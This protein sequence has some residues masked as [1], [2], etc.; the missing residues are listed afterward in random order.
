VGRTPQQ[1]L[2]RSLVGAVCCALGIA[3]LASAAAAPRKVDPRTVPVAS[4]TIGWTR[5][6]AVDFAA[7]RLLAAGGSGA[8]ASLRISPLA[9]LDP[10][11]S[12]PL[13]IT[14]GDV[15]EVI[16]DGS[17]AYVCSEGR[18]T[19]VDL[20]SNSVLRR[21]RTVGA[22]DCALDSSRG[23]LYALSRSFVTSVA[24]QVPQW[25]AEY[26]V[27]AMSAT[28]GTSIARWTVWRGQDAP[29]QVDPDTGDRLQLSSDGRWLYAGLYGIGQVVK[30]DTTSGT[31]VA[32]STVSTPVE[33]IALD[34]QN[35]R[36]LWLGGG[37][38]GALTLD[39]LALPERGQVD[40][41]TTILV[42]DPTSGVA[43]AGSPA[44]SK[45]AI[46]SLGSLAS[47]FTVSIADPSSIAAGPAGSF[48][49][50]GGIGPGSIVNRYS[51][52]PGRA[53]P[54]QP[55]SPPQEVTV[56][57]SSTG[58]EVRWSPPANE[59]LSKPTRYRVV[60]VPGGRTCATAASSCSIRS[61]R[62]GI[63]YRFQVQAGNR[64]GWGEQATSQSILVPRPSSG[65]PNPSPSPKPSAS[66]S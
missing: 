51:L 61:L 56:R 62:P 46:L 58:A 57:L 29:A 19:I 32:M 63:R 54:L 12:I 7:Q 11:V 25:P 36:L 47:D 31:P 4:A 18:V 20:A 14:E 35:G 13:Q 3:G 64:L 1:V 43:Y 16:V 30:V 49:V 59:A 6:I 8:D 48:L 40:R 28:T 34:E 17:L 66:L 60:A 50:S 2:S 22:R 55:A 26:L 38:V 44:A 27:D 45:V 65:R 53:I 37:A 10:A 41:A 21:W 5:V 24:G 39:L 15:Q 9:S 33:A 23:I 42:A 52:D